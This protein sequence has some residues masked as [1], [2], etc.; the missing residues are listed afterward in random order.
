MAAKEAK[1]TPLVA[2]EEEMHLDDFLNRT[3][4]AEGKVESLSAFA[5]QKKAAGEIKK[6]LSKWLADFRKFESDI[7][8]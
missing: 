7:P 1:E 6:P 3:E 2:V 5:K 4:A 8:K